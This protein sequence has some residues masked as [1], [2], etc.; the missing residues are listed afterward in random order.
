MI[1]DVMYA[2][3]KGNINASSVGNILNIGKFGKRKDVMRE[4][5]RQH[6][7]APREVMDNVAIDHGNY[8][9][10]I[11]FDCFNNE[12]KQ[13]I[14]NGNL[15][16]KKLLCKKINKEYKTKKA[17]IG[18]GWSFGATPDGI[19]ENGW[20]LEIKCPFAKMSGNIKNSLKETGTTD[21]LVSIFDKSMEHYYAQI[22]VQAYVFDLEAVYFYQFAGDKAGKGEIVK[23]NDDYLNGK[24]KLLND[25]YS[26]YLKTIASDELSKEHLQDLEFTIDFDHLEHDKFLEKINYL[27]KMQEKQKEIKL[28]VDESKEQLKQ[29]VMDYKDKN[30]VCA[31]KFIVKKENDKRS[32]LTLFETKRKKIDFDKIIKDN[33]ISNAVLDDYSKISKSIGFKVTV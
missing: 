15:G 16:A 24:I 20:G 22:Q 25:F 9:E 30:D 10:Q 11:A 27:S 6:F 8:Y 1:D 26:D 28:I 23:R 33:G 7:D 2:K 21:C 19:L 18:S 4:M 14:K 29:M 17:N 3:R 5:V 31:N 32:L 12:I 13:I